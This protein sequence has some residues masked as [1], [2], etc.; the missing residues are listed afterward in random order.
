MK[1]A[2]LGLRA[3]GPG[4]S[5][6]VEKA[7]EELSTR[8]VQLGHD[9]TVFCRSRYA[10]D[11]GEEFK[12][13]T[14]RKLPAIYTK[15]LEA[16]SNT[17]AAIAFSLRGYD[18]VHV[19]AT[20]PALLSF[21]PR[22]FGR[23]VVVTVHGLDWKR[24]KWGFVARWALKAGAWASVAFPNRTIVVSKTL[25]EHYSTVY[26]RQVDYIPNGVTLPP[27]SSMPSPYPSA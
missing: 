12:G 20:G 11:V 8:Y 7:I 6:G 14:L 3:I 15:H 10:Q 22:L 1:I 27:R 19:N 13:V 9:V 5:G 2:I 4:A 25:R 23:R 21:L 24:E 16:I 17:V 18:V 26:R